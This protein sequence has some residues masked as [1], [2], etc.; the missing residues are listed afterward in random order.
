MRRHVKRNGRRCDFNVFQ[1]IR[2]NLFDGGNQTVSHP[3]FLI[4]QCQSSSHE[5]NKEIHL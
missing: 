2:S 5:K 3:L 1:Q 4:L